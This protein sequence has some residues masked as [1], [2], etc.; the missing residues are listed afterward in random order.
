[1]LSSSQVQTSLPLIGRQ[2]FLVREGHFSFSQ[3]TVSQSGAGQDRLLLIGRRDLL[4]VRNNFQ[5]VRARILSN[6]GKA[7]DEI[8]PDWLEFH[9]T[10]ILYSSCHLATGSP[11][12]LTFTIMFFRQSSVRP[13]L[14]LL[15]KCTVILAVHYVQNQQ[16]VH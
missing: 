5:W 11:I 8:P 15:V 4:Y 16:L 2:A 1:M 6:W 9:P 13:R 14:L 7:P 12:G 10:M 3:S